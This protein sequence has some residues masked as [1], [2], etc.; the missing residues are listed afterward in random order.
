MKGGRGQQLGAHDS[1]QG[2]RAAESGHMVA[3]HAQQQQ[4]SPVLLSRPCIH[5]PLLPVHAVVRV[6]SS[7]SC[8]QQWE[9]PELHG[10][11][12]HTA[13]QRPQHMSQHMNAPYI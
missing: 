10:R 9:P 7:D 2:C 13:R 8:Q 3:T 4:G 6:C 11:A 1:A 12:D 5:T